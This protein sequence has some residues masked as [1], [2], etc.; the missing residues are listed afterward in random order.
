M[1]CQLILQPTAPR[2]RRSRTRQTAP[3]IGVVKALCGFFLKLPENAGRSLTLS[4]ASALVPERPRAHL[5]V[6]H[7]TAHR[8]G[9]RP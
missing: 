9:G 3:M 8:E 6:T 7:S 2:L 1:T 4:A 5:V